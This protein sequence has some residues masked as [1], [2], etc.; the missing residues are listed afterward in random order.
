MQNLTLAAHSLGLGTVHVGAFNAKKAADIL[1]VPEGF[2]VVEMTPLGYP[3]HE[4]KAPPRKELSEIA[5][6]DKYGAE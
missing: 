5:F 3:D 6:H 2:C 4:A 1:A